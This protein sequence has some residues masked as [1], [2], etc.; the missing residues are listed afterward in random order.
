LTTKKT[1]PDVFIIESLRFDD[2]EHSH[3]EGQFLAHILR[4]A[5]RQ[6]KYFYI[7]TKRELEEVL[8]KF[9]ESGFRYLHISC[10]ANQKGI[11][12]T[13]DHLTVGD[14]G[15]MLRPYI[16]NRRVFFSACTLAT[17]QL[18]SALLRG[19]GCYSVI[20]PSESVRFDAAA[21]FWASLYHLMFRN[22]KK[23]MKRDEL[24]EN[25]TALSSLFGIRMRFYSASS[26]AT[27]G[28][29]EVTIAP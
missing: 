23:A 18:A 16:E 19:T 28:Y 17:D 8:D 2:E 27:K 7:R 6:Y 4:L 5:D 24:A 20:A 14:L 1:K 29:R 15:D 21:L 3:G 26:T 11:A 10:H 12:L 13:L 22:D 25:L 9:E